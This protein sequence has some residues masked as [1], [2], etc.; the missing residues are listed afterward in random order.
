LQAVW[1]GTWNKTLRSKLTSSLP[2]RPSIPEGNSHRALADSYFLAVVSASSPGLAFRLGVQRRRRSSH[3]IHDNGR[4]RRRHS[5][6]KVLVLLPLSST[7]DCHRDFSTKQRGEK[8][9]MKA[10]TRVLPCGKR[11]PQSSSA[12]PAKPAYS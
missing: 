11:S 8:F 2:S 7:S 10:G 12:S 3:I 4:S 5:A 6:P 1:Q 9:N